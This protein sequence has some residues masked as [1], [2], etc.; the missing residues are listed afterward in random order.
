MKQ[1]NSLTSSK[2][3]SFLQ[4]SA[5][6]KLSRA[7]RRGPAICDEFASNLKESDKTGP[8]GIGGLPTDE[9]SDISIRYL[10]STVE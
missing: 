6:V 3:M 10:E 7:K 8:S 5:V 4:S 1:Y 2:S 9:L